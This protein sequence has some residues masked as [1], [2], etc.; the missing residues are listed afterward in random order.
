[1]ILNKMSTGSCKM[2]IYVEMK[3]TRETLSVTDINGNKM[4]LH[5]LCTCQQE[6]MTF[7]KRVK[8]Y[9]ILST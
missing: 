5:N 1:M 2:I 6:Y 4:F 8:I 7:R 3:E 9:S